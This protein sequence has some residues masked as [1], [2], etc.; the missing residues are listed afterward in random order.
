MTA[1]LEARVRAAVAALPAADGRTARSRAA[2]LGALARLGAPFDED[3]DPTHVTGSAIVVGP[4][5]V[6]LHRH[7]RLGVWMQ[8]GGHLDP[9][10]APWDAARRE[11]A[12]ETGLVAA[13]PPGGARLVHVD[14][15]PAPRGHTHL[16][17]R[18]LLEADG[19]P[20]PPPGESQAVRWFAWPEA[21]RT[22]DTA[23]AGGLAA[24]A[25]GLGVSAGGYAR[26]VTPTG[27][28][29]RR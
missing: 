15:H 14:V 18:Y 16:D 4:R 1:G 19:D 17:L 22:A 24:L 29:E 20:A 9:G 2:V 6:L 7:K 26:G 12:E 3:A 11:T 27:P 8:P 5:G 28:G 23:L 21:L 25:S 10:E 13:H